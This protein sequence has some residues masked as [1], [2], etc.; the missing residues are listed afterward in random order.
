MS[1]LPDV[2]AVRVHNP[3]SPPST[4]SR[5]SSSDSR[6]EPRSPPP[7]IEFDPK[8]GF[9]DYTE[10]KNLHHVRVCHTC[11]Q[12]TAHASYAPSLHV[13]VRPHASCRSKKSCSRTAEAPM[14]T[15]R[16]APSPS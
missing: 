4:N 1:Q 14:P 16:P 6:D 10:E 5:R 12:G 7:H 3:D 2:A 13:L 11:M 8:S 9:F 15:P